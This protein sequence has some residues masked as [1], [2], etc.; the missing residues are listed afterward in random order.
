MILTLD[1][2]VTRADRQEH[3][4]QLRLDNTMH[5]WRFASALQSQVA[6]KMGPK[7]EPESK[8]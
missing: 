4:R 2:R 5:F 3:R 7:A 8:I 1:I 6:P